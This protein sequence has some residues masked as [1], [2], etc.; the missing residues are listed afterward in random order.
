[1]LLLF[2]F[3]YSLILTLTL[4]ALFPSQ[5]F[6]YFAPLLV[7]SIYRYSRILCLWLALICG[8]ILDLLSAEMRF[9]IYALNYTLCVLMLGYFKNYFFED[10]FSTIPLMTILF[11]YLSTIIFLFL[12]YAFNSQALLSWEWVKRE[13]I[14]MPLSNAI[15]AILTFTVLALIFPR[16]TKK[17]PKLVKFKGR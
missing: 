8:L 4:P 14:Q 1:M 9:G 10:S 2:L 6:A 16:K 3:T 5:R 11:S 17:A 13:L 12:L 7:F 15:Y